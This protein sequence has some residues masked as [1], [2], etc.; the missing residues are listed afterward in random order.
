MPLICCFCCS[1]TELPIGLARAV[2]SA[3]IT[4][5]ATTVGK[6]WISNCHVPLMNRKMSK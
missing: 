6:V 4:V 1:H 3:E 2:L 5:M